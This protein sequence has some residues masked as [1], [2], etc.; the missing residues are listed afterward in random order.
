M[1]ALL[2]LLAVGSVWFTAQL[3]WALWRAKRER[4]E[5]G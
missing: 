5:K 1:R 3:A 2:V 4:E